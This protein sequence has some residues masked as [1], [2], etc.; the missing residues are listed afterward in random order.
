MRKHLL[1][2]ME[3]THTQRKATAVTE[4]EIEQAKPSAQIAKRLAN[5]RACD[6]QLNAVNQIRTSRVVGKYLFIH[7]LINQSAKKRKRE[8]ERGGWGWGEKPQTNNK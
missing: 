6:V 7:S 2:Q 1:K 4:A 3:R 5:S 8:R